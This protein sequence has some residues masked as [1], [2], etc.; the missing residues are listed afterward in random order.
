LPGAAS[1]A[2]KRYAL[3]QKNPKPVKQ[4]LLNKPGK[5][6]GLKE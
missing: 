4:F 2:S 6:P 3:A 1:F 5:L